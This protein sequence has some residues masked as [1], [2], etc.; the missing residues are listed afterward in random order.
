MS[1]SLRHPMTVAE[2]LAWEARQEFRWEFDGV[3]PVAMTGGTAAH[4]TI[5]GNIFLPCEPG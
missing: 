3:H 2:F 5:S 4:E 1:A